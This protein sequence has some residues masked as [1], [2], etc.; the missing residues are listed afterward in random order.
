MSGTV[1]GAT[2]STPAN[3]RTPIAEDGSECDAQ[4]ARKLWECTRPH[5]FIPLR[6]RHIGMRV[7]EYE[8]C[9]RCGADTLHEFTLLELR[10]WESRCFEC[11]P[12]RR[13]A[14]DG[15]D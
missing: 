15:Q 5:A 12:R 3:R 14:D 9:M 8:H 11:R 1:P 2:A 6:E 10:T 13:E 4:Y 7:A